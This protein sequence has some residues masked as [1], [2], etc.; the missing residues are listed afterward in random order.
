M[1]YVASYSGVDVYEELLGGTP[2]MR[3]VSDDWVNATQILKVAGLPKAQRTRVLERE[4]H[5]HTHE[6]IQGGYGRFQGTWVPLDFARAFAA[7]YCEGGPIRVLE[8]APGVDPELER[9][10]PKGRTGGTKPAKPAK[11][12]EGTMVLGPSSVHSQQ[13]QQSQPGQ[14]VPQFAHFNNQAIPQGFY[15]P[16]QAQAQA[17]AMGH[18]QHTQ[19]TQHAQ[20]SQNMQSQHPHSHSHSHQQPQMFQD[21]TTQLLNYFI[22]DNLPIP[23]FLFGAPPDFNPNE[24]IDDEGHTP[25]HWATSLALL[26]VVQLLLQLGADPHVLNHNGVNPL[27]KLVCFSNAFDNQSFPA[28]LSTF[29]P[30]AT[31]F[32]VALLYQDGKGETTIHHIVRLL[33]AEINYNS[34]KVTS[35]NYYLYQALV[36]LAGI[37]RL[38]S[39]SNIRDYNGDTVWSAAA[40][41]G[42]D[43]LVTSIVS[44]LS[45]VDTPRTIVQM[46]PPA[47]NLLDQAGDRDM[48]NGTVSNGTASNGIIVTTDVETTPGP[49]AQID[50]DNST[51]IETSTPP[52][53]GPPSNLL[54]ELKTV[55]KQFATI[56]STLAKSLDS[57]IDDVNYLA[58]SIAQIEASILEQ[59]AKI[60][61]LPLD[62]DEIK[63]TMIVNS[64][65]VE[66]K[67]SSLLNLLERDQ[68][69]NVAKL[70]NRHEDAIQ[71]HDEDDETILNRSIYLTLLQVKR[72]VILSCL[73]SCETSSVEKISLYHKLI[74]SLCD[75]PKDGIT[76]ELLNGLEAFLS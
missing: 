76:Q 43:H 21:Y 54:L 10:K 73:V 20:H 1:L 67:T 36:Y 74:A 33:A 72:Q 11:M 3:R 60:A 17:Q 30:S 51:T 38:Q 8:Y 64:S 37:N 40:K 71:V 6:K 24:P 39:L 46:T 55:P 58:T 42:L 5:N 62:A 28:I 56:A 25:L 41:V 65:V 48:A 59:D 31:P 19:H 15:Q 7:K 23:S 16:S 13:S 27:G 4:V 14:Q 68:A 35:L 18:T 57:K 75:V 50:F 52:P 53:T 34:P 29:T 45:V 49:S 2:L 9:R 47:S 22:N 61:K 69:L 32:G 12:G 44:N 66:E 26:D 63:S 70:V